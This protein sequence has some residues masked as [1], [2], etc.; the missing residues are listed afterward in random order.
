[1]RMYVLLIN[2]YGLEDSPLGTHVDETPTQP[3][4]PFS[5]SSNVPGFPRLGVYP[6]PCA[7][8]GSP[9]ADPVFGGDRQLSL[10]IGYGALP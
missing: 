4:A 6:W 10:G 8:K 9:V 1:V 5:H 2:Y 3:G 7:L